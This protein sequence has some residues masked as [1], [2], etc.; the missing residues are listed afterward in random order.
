MLKGTLTRDKLLVDVEGGGRGLN[1][2]T[3]DPDSDK[4]AMPEMKYC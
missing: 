2:R 4:F 3:G 1:T